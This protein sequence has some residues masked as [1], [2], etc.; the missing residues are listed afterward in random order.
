MKIY[1]DIAMP[2][3]LFFV[4]IVATLLNE[5]AEGKLKTTLEKRDFSVK[6]TLLLVGAMVIVISLVVIIPTNALMILFLFSY[7]L[8]LFMF[9]YIFSNKRLF[10]AVFPPALFVGLYMILNQTSLWSLYLVN[11]YA[12]VFAVLITLYLGSLFNWKTT[13]A[14]AAVLTIVDMVLVLVTGTMVQAVDAARSLNL[15][16]MVTVPLVPFL[17]TQEG[18]LMMNLGLGDF[19]FAG[20]LSIQTMRRY[21]RVFAFCSVVGITLSFFA[22]EVFILNYGLPAFPGTLMILCGWL[23][24]V[25][26]KRIK[27]QANE[28]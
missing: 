11:L 26:W 23:P 19:F 12:L 25:F 10:L 15:P 8:L 28:S 3:T 13:F 20:L 4:T 14:F 2:L 1:F 18:M 17:I 22:F 21:G 9:T 7:S 16:I 5:K 24:F 27:S 6:E